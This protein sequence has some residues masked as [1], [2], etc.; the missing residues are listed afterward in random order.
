MIKYN[1]YAN[2]C[3]YAKITTDGL[4]DRSA[5]GKD[6]DWDLKK[7]QNT[8]LSH[9]Y[10]EIDD[11]KADRLKEC[12]KFLIFAEKPDGSGKKLKKANFCRVRLCPICQWRRSLKIYNQIRQVLDMAINDNYVF[13]FATFTVR[14]CLPGKLSDNL[15]KILKSFNLLTKYVDIGKAWR[16]YFRA[17]EITHN[18]QH[19]TY[20]PHIHT[21]IA[22]RKS[23]F[24]GRDYLSH[25]RLTE[26]WQRALKCDYTPIIDVRRV[27]GDTA[28]IIAEIAKYAVKTSDYIYFDDWQLTVDTVRLLDVVLA[29][30]RFLGMGGVL[31]E[32]HA[33]LN[34]VDI[35]DDNNLVNIDEDKPNIDEEGRELIYAWLSGYNQYR[36]V[37]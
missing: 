17:L 27:K 13:V 14:N 7:L 26:L 9:V 34:L 5:R 10:S 18:V 6:R 21:L 1:R 15:D 23:Y 2:N 37:E 36:R 8:Y 32:Y 31:K 12:A 25:A 19:D 24:T 29:N 4:V 16:G 20:H 33:K 30:R 3:Q 28:G 22:V 11:K 35:E